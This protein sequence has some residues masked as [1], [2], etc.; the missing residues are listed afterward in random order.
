MS[1]VGRGT[2][3]KGSVVSPHLESHPHPAVLSVEGFLLSR[4]GF[5]GGG[6]LGPRASAGTLVMACSAVRGPGWGASP[7]PC[8]GAE[9]ALRAPSRVLSPP[10][11]AGAHH[12]CRVPASSGLLGG[13]RLGL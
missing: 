2:E 12:W 3:L 11:D 5:R 10:R 7:I 1:S 9:P 8:V 4:Q 6:W 13:T